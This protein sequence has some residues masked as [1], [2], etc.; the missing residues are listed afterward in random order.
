MTD[1][2]RDLP[3]D[4]RPR[5][6]MYRHG[7]G[8]LS[9]AELIAILLGSGTRGRNAIQL[10]REMLKEGGLRAL[11]KR[12]INQLTKITGL[13][14]AKIC[15]VLA[16]LELGKRVI[17]N[18]PDE[19]LPYETDQLG[20]SLIAYYAKHRQERLGALFLDTRRRILKQSEIY[21]GTINNA[22]VSTRDIVT[23]ALVENA[24]GVVIYHNH[25]SGDPAPSHEDTT[26]T[27]KLQQSLG[28]IDVEL[29]D[30]LIIGAHRYYSM[31]EQGRL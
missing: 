8:T 28:H 10:G 30:H 4:E 20:R 16:A 11:P 25:P 3:V 18:V 7:A 1:V 27:E 13:G 22:L 12:D 29:V 15:R 6:R 14:M 9:N 31:A 21:I 23:H 17:E 19:P 5:E 26:F 2:I 24:T